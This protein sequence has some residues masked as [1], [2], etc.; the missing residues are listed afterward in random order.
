MYTSKM[1][2]YVYNIL[3]AYRETKN[4]KSSGIDQIPGELISKVYK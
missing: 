3:I 4:H 1:K 2:I